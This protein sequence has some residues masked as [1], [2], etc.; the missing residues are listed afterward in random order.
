MITIILSMEY[1]EIC[2]FAY[3]A[4][5]TYDVLVNSY[6]SAIVLLTDIDILAWPRF[7][8]ECMGML[9]RIAGTIWGRIGCALAVFGAYL[10]GSIRVKSGSPQFRGQHRNSSGRLVSSR[11][12]ATENAKTRFIDRAAGEIKIRGSDAFGRPQLLFFPTVVPFAC[13]R[14][15]AGVNRDRWNQC[16][17]STRRDFNSPMRHRPREKGILSSF[18]RA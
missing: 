11:D 13:T 17:H 4:T 16:L 5:A 18:A 15:P 1:R 12:R 7:I 8:L 2:R 10:R 6:Y 9:I 14:S 3:N